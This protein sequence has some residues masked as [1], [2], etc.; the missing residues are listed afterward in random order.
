ML[1]NKKRRPRTTARGR[2]IDAS[3]FREI[4]ELVGHQP[5]RRDLLIEHLHLVQDRFGY[6]SAQHLRALAELHG[7]G[8]AEVFEVASFYRHFDIVKEDGSPPPGVTI[9][10]CDSLSCA[11]AGG[12]ALAEAIESCADPIVIRVQRVPCVSRCA[13]AP[14]AVIGGNPLEFA[15]ADAALKAAAVGAM[16]CPLP[17]AIGLH[18][19]RAGGGYRLLGEVRAGRPSVVSDVSAHGTV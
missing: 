8:Q 4:A 2:Q 11:L 5:P 12:E 3:A 1:E 7:I 6:L 9:R 14:V 16:R 13:A 18:S 10:V 17:N 19:Y 15:T